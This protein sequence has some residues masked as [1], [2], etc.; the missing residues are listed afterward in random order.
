MAAPMEVPP[1]SGAWQE[2]V[3]VQ[4]SQMLTLRQLSCSIS[5]ASMSSPLTDAE[6]AAACKREPPD[7][8]CN[9]EGVMQGIWARAMPT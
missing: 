8:E 5:L 3:M 4:S 9:K 6:R 1:V 7:T 2:A